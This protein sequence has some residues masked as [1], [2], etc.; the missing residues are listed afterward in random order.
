MGQQ[1]RDCSRIVQADRVVEWGPIVHAALLNIS[2][3]GEE[4]AHDV[5]P[6]L[7][8][9]G[10]RRDQRRKSVPN[11]GVGIC[12]MLKKGLNENKRAPINCVFE[13][14]V[15]QP[16]PPGMQAVREASWVSQGV[17]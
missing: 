8:I 2:A 16:R 6:V 7:A 11:R 13:G 10:E 14:K 3:E 12:A 1:Q 17:E 15:A 4:Q 5:Q 9:G